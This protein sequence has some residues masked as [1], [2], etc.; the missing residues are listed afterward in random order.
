MTR[1]EFI[2]KYRVSMSAETSRLS[3]LAV[4]T[5]IIMAPALILAPKII[6][7]LGETDYFNWAVALDV[8]S[9]LGILGCC[10]LAL[11]F[12]SRR[13]S[14]PYGVPCPACGGKLYRT[15][16]RLALM[17]GNCGFCGEK[18]LDINGSFSPDMLK[19]FKPY[20]D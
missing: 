9:A 5:V 8:Y 3:I 7:H 16:A 13:L 6:N 18:A 11:A 4:I 15:S 12:A 1:E 17:T 20:Y 14:Q 10:V 19:N 2:Q